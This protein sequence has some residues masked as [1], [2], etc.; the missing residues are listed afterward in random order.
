MDRLTGDDYLLFAYREVPQHSFLAIGDGETKVETNIPVWE[1]DGEIRE[2]S[3]LP[4]EGADSGSLKGSS[5]LNG[6]GVCAICDLG[7]V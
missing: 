5:L 3:W 2:S 6:E 4:L 1:D 7:L